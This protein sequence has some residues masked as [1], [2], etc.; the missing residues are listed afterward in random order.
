MEHQTD[1]IRKGY[2]TPTELTELGLSPSPD[3]IRKG[4]VAVVECPQPIPCNPCEAACPR[5]AI[6]VGLPITNIPSLDAN[7]CTGCGMCVH[8]CPGLAIFIV[9][10]ERGVVGLPYEFL[11]LPKAGDE[12]PCFDR[13][14]A[15]RCSGKVIRVVFKKVQDR[16]AVVYVM[17]PKDLVMEI[18]S[19]GRL[20][21][22]NA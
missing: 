13:A 18:R 22:S 12:V 16:T 10:G 20:V 2:L 17:V 15:R 14:G 3:R 8:Q 6:K 5:G 4:P 7:K 19:V 11:P 9:D 21:A 1:Y